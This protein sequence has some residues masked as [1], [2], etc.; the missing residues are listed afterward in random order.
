MLLAPSQ[1]VTL[2]WKEVKCKF[3]FYLSIF[4]VDIK[5][6]GSVLSCAMLERSCCPA[7]SWSAVYRA[8]RRETWGGT[9]VDTWSATVNNTNWSQMEL[10]RISPI[11]LFLV[12]HSWLYSGP[13]VTPRSRWF[14]WT[15]RSPA[16]VRI[17]T[18]NFIQIWV[19]SA[20]SSYQAFYILLLSTPTLLNCRMDTKQ[21]AESL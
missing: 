4:W 14:T 8:V 11:W 12:K 10:V 19:E 1:V 21:T 20:D 16:E 9:Q 7:L 17:T 2:I 13:S 6:L 5:C 3:L 15:R 18:N